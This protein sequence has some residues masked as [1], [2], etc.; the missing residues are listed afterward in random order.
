MQASDKAFK[1]KWIFAAGVVLLALFSIGGAIVMAAHSRWGREKMLSC[2]TDALK[3]SGWT[4]SAQEIHGTIPNEITLYSISIESPR[5]DIIAID[6]IQAKISIFR[7]FNKEIG[8]TEFHADGIEWTPGLAKKDPSESSGG[9]RIDWALNFPHVSL[10]RV[11]IPNVSMKSDVSGQ[12]KI[13]RKLRTAFAKLDIRFPELSDA[14]AQVAF[15]LRPSGLAQLKLDVE[16]S[17]LNAV[18]PI[19]LPFSGKGEIHFY[20]KGPYDSMVGSMFGRPVH[21][22]LEGLIRGEV[23][24]A[25]L[26]SSP[27]IRNFV[28]GSWQFFSIW[29]RTPDQSVRLSRIL[30]NND[31]L[32]AKG[33]LSFD[34][35]WQITGST[36]GLRLQNP[37]RPFPMA[38]AKIDGFLQMDGPDGGTLSFSSPRIEWDRWAAEKISGTL[39]LK[40]E[41]PDWSA[42]LNFEALALSQIWNVQCSLLFPDA[43]ILKIDALSARSTAAHIEGSLELFPGQLF[44]G[45]L[46]GRIANLH[47]LD[48]PFYGS[49]DAELRLKIGDT[50]G[51]KSQLAEIDMKGSDLFYKDAQIEKA[52]LYADLSGSIVHPSG[53]AYAEIQRGRWKT[54]FMETASIQTTGA[55]KEWP[56]ELSAEG[57]W[58][59]PFQVALEGFWSY[60][61]PLFLLQL[62]NLSGSLFSHALAL[63]GPASL[64]TGPDG[65]QLTSLSIELEDAQLQAS[66]DRSGKK[67]EARLRLERFPI[68]FL[69]INPL[70]LSVNG[71]VDLDARIF[72]DAGGASGSINA[73]IADVEIAD[74]LA[75]AP[76]QAQG[77]IDARLEKN[78]LE[79]DAQLQ[80]RGSELF[81]LTFDLPMTVSLRPFKAAPELDASAS[82]RL[83]M[84]GNID[85]LLDFFDLGANRLEGGSECD[86]TLSGSLS[87]PLI[88]GFCRLTNGRYENYYSGL[89]LQNISAEISGEG[90]SL[91][92]RSLTAVDSQKKGRFSLNGTMRAIYRDRF[93]FRFEGA[94]SRMNVADIQWMRVEAGGNLEISG[95][96]D[97]ARVVAQAAVLE[98]DLSIPD[99]I[100]HQMPNLQVKYVNAP[101]PVPDEN[102]AN[103][104]KTY[105]IFLDLHVAA[106]GGVFVSG[107][108]LSS[109]WK[110]DFNLGGTYTDIEAKGRLDMIDGSF[111]F[112]GRSFQLTE[113]SL[114]FSGQPH[115]MPFLNLA[116]QMVL[117]DLTIMARLKGPL[118][119]PELA[120]QSS[121]PLPMGSIL[122]HLLFGQSFSE[123]NALQAAQ[124]VNSISTFSGGAA[125]VFENT[126][127]SLGLDRL[128]IVAT[129]IGRDGGQS[130][131]LQV[132]KYVTRGVLVSVSQ[133]PEGGST[134]LGVEVDLTN[135]FIFQA[136]SQQE[137]EQGKFTIKWNLNY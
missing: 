11:T 59:D 57:V 96:L 134:N 54:L 94:F 76:L 135:G 36:L 48:M 32:S 38:D 102:P 23:E 133:G 22:S 44:S 64:K 74:L 67:T 70:N 40:K 30:A 13:G 100:P 87:H 99:R 21:S 16:S 3:K 108:G 49:V 84:N 12:I 92:L 31:Y 107:R 24:V 66:I 72:E 69:S 117:Q 122:A 77:R 71:I 20:A 4:A 97:S 93:P 90:D 41:N 65:L 61:R 29:E 14:N 56:V 50:E 43:P 2:L 47:Q 123:I 83:R 103:R 129:P 126:R 130:I 125:S 17:S 75:S 115:E 18:S 89:T 46:H 124:I 86:L 37:H 78:R 19:D 39:R 9:G 5:G 82:A 111:F 88:E 131:A 34:K 62:R 98:S 60:D 53:H 10:T 120:F 26:P 33:A 55:E 104:P 118:T 101:K 7:L 63:T 128:R 106:P 95:N 58:K 25:G 68:D 81:H 132:G 109:E 121:P 79:C 137:P 85:E 110:G 42:D 114:T 27:A 6:E 113:G 28:E 51:K 52:Y 127:R 116:G 1:K 45:D 112:S 91:A 35:R 105:P 80:V 8:F 119:S 136:E 73:Q 15:Y